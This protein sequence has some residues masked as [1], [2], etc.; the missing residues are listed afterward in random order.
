MP[1]ILQTLKVTTGIGVRRDQLEDFYYW[2]CELG[3]AE[4]QRTATRDRSRQGRQL[5]IKAPEVSKPGAIDTDDSDW[6]AVVL[7]DTVV[8]EVTKRARWG[9]ARE[10][11]RPNEFLAMDLVPYG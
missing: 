3:G 7:D 1:K 9:K 5:A 6:E 2:A 8:R 4:K 10:D 11:I